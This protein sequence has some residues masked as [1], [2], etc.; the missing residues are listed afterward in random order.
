[1]RR[2]DKD[3]L[4]KSREVGAFLNTLKPEWVQGMSR[5]SKIYGKQ[6]T[7]DNKTIENNENLGFHLN[8]L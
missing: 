4:A 8:D 5:R 6:R 7:W 3:Y 1:M 2:N